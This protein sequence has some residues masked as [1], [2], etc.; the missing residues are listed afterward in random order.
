MF[1]ISF[2]RGTNDRMPGVDALRVIEEKWSSKSTET[3]FKR[4]Q[5]FPPPWIILAGDKETSMHTQM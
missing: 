1:S 4:G 2:S 3:H 5:I